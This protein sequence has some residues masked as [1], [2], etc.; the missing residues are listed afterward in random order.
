MPAPLFG[1]PHKRLEDQRLLRGEASF[2]DD[3]RLVG[4][5]H[6]AFV[7]SIH[8][9]A[10]VR[11]TSPPAIPGSSEFSAPRTCSPD[12]PLPTFP[13]WSATKRCVPAVSRRWPPRK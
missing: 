6:V 13:P 3:L 10:R 11:V 5:L 4:V 7:R 9:H 1:Q 2:I 12:A 8:A